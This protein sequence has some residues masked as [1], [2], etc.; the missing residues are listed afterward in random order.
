MII[1]AFIFDKTPDFYVFHLRDD[2]PLTC[3]LKVLV[4]SFHSFAPSQ[5]FNNVF[6]FVFVGPYSW[7]FADCLQT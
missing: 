2:Q 5:R 7:K 3:C 6:S 1:V 4:A